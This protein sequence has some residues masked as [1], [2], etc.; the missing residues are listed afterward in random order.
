MEI[1]YQIP[2]KFRGGFEIRVWIVSC[3]I[4]QRMLKK[5]SRRIK[6]TGQQPARTY[7][8]TLKRYTNHQ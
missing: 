6:T 5:S 1:R 7:S 4:W 3:T 2:Q 8:G